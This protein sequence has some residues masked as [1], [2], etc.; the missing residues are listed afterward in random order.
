VGRNLD[1]YPSSART[2][3]VTARRCT[4]WWQGYPPGAAESYLIT[5][6]DI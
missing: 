1:L 4:K 2:S 3:A 6:D 5:F